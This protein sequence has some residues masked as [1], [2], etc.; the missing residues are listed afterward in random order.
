VNGSKLN[1]I[2]GV[3][4]W[5]WQSSVPEVPV[6]IALLKE[7]VT[8]RSANFQA[9][10]LSDGLFKKK[11]KKKK[12]QSSTACISSVGYYSVMMFS[13]QRGGRRCPDGTEQQFIFGSKKHFN[14]CNPNLRQSAVL[15]LFKHLQCFRREGYC[16]E[17]KQVIF[18]ATI[19]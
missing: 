13:R 4:N 18:E 7:S 19:F 11:K 1:I 9:N 14:D 15:L 2:S 17:E 5:I 3:F 16:I 8:K 12:P 6:Q 10:A